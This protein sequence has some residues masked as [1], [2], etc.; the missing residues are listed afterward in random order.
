VAFSGVP[1]GTT[2]TVAG[3]YHAQKDNYGLD[4]QWHL[5]PKEPMVA[6]G[7]I[8]GESF[9][10][11]QTNKPLVDGFTKSEYEKFLKEIAD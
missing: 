6:Q 10:F 3:I 11:V 9:V 5:K 1:K 4:I 7:E 8:G 2:G